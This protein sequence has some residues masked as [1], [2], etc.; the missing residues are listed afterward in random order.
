MPHPDNALPGWPNYDS[1][2]VEGR[3]PHSFLRDAF[4][5]DVAAEVPAVRLTH[6]QWAALRSIVLTLAEV[7]AGL[8][9]R[10]MADALI[11]GAALEDAGELALRLREQLCLKETGG[12]ADH[13]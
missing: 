9:G 6:W 2:I 7:E 11:R 10:T 3:P 8:H 5:P 4:K 13:G 12:D 1:L